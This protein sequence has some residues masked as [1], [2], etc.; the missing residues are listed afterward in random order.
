MAVIADTTPIAVITGGSRGLGRNAALKLAGHGVDVLLTYRSN[1]G[2]AESVVAQIQAAGRRAAALPLDVSVS[3][4]FAAFATQVRETLRKTWQRER[5]N[6]LLNNAGTGIHASFAETT[7][8]QFDEMVAIHL[9]SAFFL[10]QR[11]LPLLADGGRILNVSSGLTRFAFPGFAAYA[12]MKGAVEVLTRY[13]AK[14]LGA[15]RISVN[16]IAPGAIATDFGGGMV[17][18]NAQ[19]NAQIAS[20]TA[21]GRVGEPDDIGGVIASMLSDETGWINGQRIEISGGV[22]L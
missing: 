4:G 21:L 5:F 14:E 9:K 19:V 6:F 20:L 11:L 22:L 7:E 3:S 8:A 10:T 18:D 1:R 2:E 17:R 13:M 16:T 15:R 12:S